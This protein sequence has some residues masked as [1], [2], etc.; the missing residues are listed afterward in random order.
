M[1]IVG[2]KSC[3]FFLQVIVATIAFGMGIDKPDVRFVIHHSLSKSMENYYQES[4]RGGRD[5]APADCVLFFRAADVFRQST[6]V[7]TEHTGLQNLYTMIRY[8]LNVTNCRRSL[9]ARSFGEKWCETDC[10]AACDVCV[11]KK[12]DGPSASKQSEATASKQ[13]VTKHCQALIELIEH[14]QTQDK[15]LTSQMLMESWRGQGSHKLAHISASKMSITECEALLL[16]SMLEG[17]LKEDFH[18][19]PYNTICYIGL[20][21]KAGLVKKGVARITQAVRSSVKLSSS[22][23]GSSC[24]PDKVLSKVTKQTTKRKLPSMYLSSSD[25]DDFMQA[26]GRAKKCCST[27]TSC[28]VIEIDSWCLAF[29]S[30]M[31]TQCDAVWM[32]LFI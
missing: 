14:A 19:T 15:R 12:Q 10:Q 27:N 31:P 28:D 16:H 1:A 5:G 26:Q 24:K 11:W 23:S 22:Q 3:V 4:G 32:L 29:D 18:F 13:D 20:G 25:D 21:R 30:W 9:I 6:M 2:C 17:V 7:F 8:C